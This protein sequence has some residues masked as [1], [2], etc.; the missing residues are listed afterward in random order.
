MSIDFKSY[1]NLRIRRSK[2]FKIEA[3]APKKTFALRGLLRAAIDNNDKLFAGWPIT[4]YLSL[5]TNYQKAVFIDTF[6]HSEYA[7]DGEL[8]RAVVADAYD[9]F[10]QEEVLYRWRTTRPTNLLDLAL[11][12]GLWR[13]LNLLVEALM[14]DA[15]SGEYLEKL[16][17]LLYNSHRLNVAPPFSLNCVLYYTER[18]PDNFWSKHLPNTRNLITAR[19]KLGPPM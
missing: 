16:D 11:A 17:Y 14:G 5:K 4:V 8:I 15:D 3:V 10:K 2:N 18:Q 19:A 1:Y 6:L 12:R 7:R 13:S 9:T